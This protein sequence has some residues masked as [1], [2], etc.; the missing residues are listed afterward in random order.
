MGILAFS[1]RDF[2]GHYWLPGDHYETLILLARKRLFRLHD[3]F[4]A[5]GVPDQA[6]RKKASAL[7]IKKGIPEMP[8]GTAHLQTPRFRNLIEAHGINLIILPMLAFII[9]FGKI[10]GG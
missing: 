7:L 3:S 1:Y 6:T 2:Q 10:L 4:Y 9:A 8:E 5:I